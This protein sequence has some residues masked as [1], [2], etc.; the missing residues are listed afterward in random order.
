MPFGWFV[1]TVTAI[2]RLWCLR[3]QK[4]TFFKENFLMRF[5][6]HLLILRSSRSL[7]KRMDGYSHPYIGHRCTVS[8][9]ATQCGVKLEETWFFDKLKTWRNL[10]FWQYRTLRNLS[11]KKRAAL[12]YGFGMSC[13]IPYCKG[14]LK[15]RT[16]TNIFGHYNARTSWYLFL[17]PG[18]SC[19]RFAVTDLFLQ[20]AP[21]R[22]M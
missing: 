8:A 5:V 3:A 15:Q 21:H 19:V 22:A 6:S 9:W 2:C 17:G 4:Q 13:Y 12:F 7:C 1:G 10:V 16:R 18:H 11:F 14:T 20:D